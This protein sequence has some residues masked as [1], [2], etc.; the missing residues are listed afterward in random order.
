MTNLK[1]LFKVPQGWYPK[2]ISKR[3]QEIKKSHKTD[4]LNYTSAITVS[5]IERKPA[6]WDIKANTKAVKALFKN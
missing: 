6:L 3:I 2:T 1:S 4:N 5:S